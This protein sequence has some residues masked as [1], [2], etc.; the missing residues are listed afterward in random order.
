[1][2]IYIEVIIILVI[3]LIILFWSVWKKRSIK[4]LLKQYSPDNDKS[5]NGENTQRKFREAEQRAIGGGEQKSTITSAT[6]VR[7]EKPRRPSVL[8]ETATSSSG[9][10]SSGFGKFLKRRRKK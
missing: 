5:K 9:K 2:K 4:K 8:Q 3:L 1:M 7:P 6:P 10:N